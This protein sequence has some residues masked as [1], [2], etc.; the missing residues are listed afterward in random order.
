MKDQALYHLL[1]VSA[2]STREL[3]GPSS[4]ARVDLIASTLT[5]SKEGRGP[6]RLEWSD[7][8]GPRAL[9]V[10]LARFSFYTRG[11]VP[12]LVA[13]RVAGIDQR[14]DNWLEAHRLWG[15]ILDD[16]RLGD[17]LRPPARSMPTTTFAERPWDRLA[18]FWCPVI[19]LAASAVAFSSG[20]P[21][22]LLAALVGAL[23]IGL[24]AAPANPA[25]VV[26]PVAIG[27][28]AATA[29]HPQSD[30][31][32]GA[33][34][35]VALLA[36]TSQLAPRADIRGWEA[37]VRALAAAAAAGLAL[38]V[39]PVAWCIAAA[40][41]LASDVVAFGLR[42]ERNRALV[43]GAWAALAV[44][45][46]GLASTVTDRV[47]LTGS[48]DPGAAWP[49]VA[50]GCAIV[51]IVV[52]VM[53]FPFGVR[54]R[55]S[56]IAAVAGCGVIALV[57]AGERATVV[58]VAPVACGVVLSRLWVRRAL[59]HTRDARTSIP[60]DGF[61]AQTREDPSPPAGG[62]VSVEFPRARR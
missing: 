21:P 41:V 60:R 45:G 61:V 39:A 56:S 35:G 42:R 55:L 37:H 48:S 40:V 4:A 51:V 22:L 12:S 26:G 18:P 1:M 19:A 3:L 14:A 49:F 2:R 13:K 25:L 24:M 52:A 29:L 62:S 23:A 6:I 15:E 20:A 16:P 10:D 54:D 32:R 57:A 47:P 36:A 7:D 38:A 59:L 28:L 58:W 5:Y 50:I 31:L 33:V 46:A 30:Q 27:L 17:T 53:S 8:S 43:T 9:D 34:A 44:V 11:D